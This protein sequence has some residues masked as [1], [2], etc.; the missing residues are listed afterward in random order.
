MIAKDSGL[1]ILF[2]E[3]LLTYVVDHQRTRVPTILSAC[4]K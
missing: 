3:S 1:E 4:V 2:G